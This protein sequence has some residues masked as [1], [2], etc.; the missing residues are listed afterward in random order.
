MLRVE[1][2]AA[3]EAMA[4]SDPRLLEEDPY[5]RANLPCGGPM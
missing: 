4:R 1:V 5:R 3:D 2:V